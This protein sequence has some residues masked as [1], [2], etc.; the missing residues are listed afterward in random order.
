LTPETHA[1]YLARSNAQKVNIELSALKDR[2]ENKLAVRM[3]TL[4]ERHVDPKIRPTAQA[5]DDF[6][7]LFSVQE[8]RISAYPPRKEQWTTMMNK[9]TATTTL[10]N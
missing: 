6:S 7:F 4:Y 9:R 1:N 10:V 5:L 8:V 2:V 3:F